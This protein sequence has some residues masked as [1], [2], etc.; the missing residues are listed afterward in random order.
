MSVTSS[1]MRKVATLRWPFT[2]ESLYFTAMMSTMRM[3]G[4]FAS[5]S[6]ATWRSAV[7]ISP[8]RWAWRASS[9]SNES[10]IP[11]SVSLILKAYQATCLVRPSRRRSA[12]LEERSE[13]GAF[14]R[15]GF[16]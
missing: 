12:S 7:G 6:G 16:E 13:F 1:S 10:K 15:L 4:S 14:E 9:S 3:F 5:K 11:Y 8:S 2:N